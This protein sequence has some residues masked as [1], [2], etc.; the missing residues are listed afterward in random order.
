MH[1]TSV[2]GLYPL[3]PLTGKWVANLSAIK[4]KKNHTY[5]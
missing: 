3:A 1:T 5:F 2:A 4:I